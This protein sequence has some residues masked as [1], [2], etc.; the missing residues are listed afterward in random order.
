MHTYTGAAV[1]IPFMLPPCSRMHLGWRPKV[2]ALA[3]L[4]D[5]GA[6]TKEIKISEDVRVSGA[7]APLVASSRSASIARWLSRFGQI[8]LWLALRRRK[9]PQR[10][11]QGKR[12]RRSPPPPKKT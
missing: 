1:P 7:S 2:L 8:R 9:V 5:H 4:L 10:G 12:I 3:A 11:G 6:E